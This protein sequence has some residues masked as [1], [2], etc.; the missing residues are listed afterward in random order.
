[1][2]RPWVRIKTADVAGVLVVVA[3]LGNFIPARRAMRV[4]P[5]IAL[6]YE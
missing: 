5:V 2:L 1:M 4:E 3:F 6:R